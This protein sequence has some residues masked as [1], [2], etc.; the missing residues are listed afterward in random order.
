MTNAQKAAT[1]LRSS[2]RR[3]FSESAMFST[4]AE[5][6]QRDGDELVGIANQLEAPDVGDAPALLQR[7]SDLMRESNDRIASVAE[8]AQIK[9]D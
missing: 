8:L 7:A 6:A 3:Y 5:L 4:L 2:A 1:L 9:P